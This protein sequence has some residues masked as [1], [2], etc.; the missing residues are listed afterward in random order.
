MTDYRAPAE[1]PSKVREI[2]E[3]TDLG[4]R[5]AR[6]AD[7]EGFTDAVEQLHDHPGAREVHAH[8]VRELLE[9]TY[10]DGLSGDDV[11]EVLTRTIGGSAD[12]QA[13]VDPSAVVVVLTGALGVAEHADDADRAPTTHTPPAE[14][15]GAAILVVTDLAKGIAADHRPYLDRAVAEIRRAQTVEMP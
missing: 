15:A 12:W 13:P 8:M 2:A 10:Q 7:L 4:I 3:A 5:A 9:T 1:W 14:L 11:S 6:A